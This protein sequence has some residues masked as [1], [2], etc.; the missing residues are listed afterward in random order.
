M[1]VTDSDE[2][3]VA[4]TQSP[5]D[6]GD[7]AREQLALELQRLG[8]GLDHQRRTGQSVE[9]VVDRGSTLGAAAAASS[10][11]QRAALAAPVDRTPSMPRHLALALGDGGR[12]PASRAP[13]PR[14]SW[15]MPEPIVPAP[16]T[17]TVAA[18]AG[19]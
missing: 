1:S 17:P 9:P 13:R 6:D 19:A 14:A 7:S 5:R 10:A 3:L 12:R 18:S 8:R 2:V 16:T 11:V 15:A 4:S